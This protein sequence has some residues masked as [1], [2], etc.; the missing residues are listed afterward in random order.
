MSGNAGELSSHS[1]HS[2]LWKAKRM[3]SLNDVLKMKRRNLIE[4]EPTA[5]ISQAATQLVEHNIGALVVRDDQR[6]LI[7]IVSER[8]IVRAVAKSDTAEMGEPVSNVMSR[9]VQTC[10]PTSDILGPLSQMD[11]HHIR[12]LPVVKDED[13]VGIVSIRDLM[14]AVLHNMRRENDDLRDMSD[15]LAEMYTKA[16]AENTPSEDSA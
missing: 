13:V 8:D 11:H 4:I 15:L 9:E 14:S 3:N 6:R 5:S 1:V 10:A 7:G 12:H 16:D 2:K